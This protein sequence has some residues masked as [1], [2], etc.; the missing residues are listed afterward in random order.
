MKII[1]LDAD[2][3]L[4]HHE[5]YVP[6]SAIDACKLAKQNGH[7]LCLC[8]G[9]QSVEI[10]GDL[11]KIDYDAIIAGSGAH[12]EIKGS[13]TIERTFSKEDLSYLISFFND[14]KIPSIYESSQNLLGDATTKE[15]IESMIQEQCAHLPKELYD[16]HGLVQVLRNLKVCNDILSCPVNKISFLKSNTSYAKIKEIVEERFDIVPATFA[17]F[18]K[19][20]GEIMDKTIT[21]AQGMKDVLEAL[22]MDVDDCIAIGDGFNDICMFELAKTSVCMGNADPAVQEKADHVTTCLEDNGIFNAF[23]F[24]DLI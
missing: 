14:Y 22:Q 24:L 8:T 13:P 17:P 18:G 3:T 10:Y 11:L 9:R 1:F 5:G 7:K 15:Y 21:K 12:I 4:L 16:K 20:S 6:Q 23:T 19:E 2:G